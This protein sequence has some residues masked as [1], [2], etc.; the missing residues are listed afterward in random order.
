MTMA[1]DSIITRLLVESDDAQL[2]RE[3]WLHRQ[4]IILVGAMVKAGYEIEDV[5][6]ALEMYS[7]MVDEDPDMFIE[8]EKGSA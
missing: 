2:A 8:V 1:N 4:M 6:Q 3:A 5:P 7:E